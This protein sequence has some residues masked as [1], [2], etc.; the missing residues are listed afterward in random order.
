MINQEPEFEE[1]EISED[2]QEF[3]TYDLYP[4]PS[5]G[6]SGAGKLERNTVR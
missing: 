5:I 6:E 3:S 2:K 4:T 1:I